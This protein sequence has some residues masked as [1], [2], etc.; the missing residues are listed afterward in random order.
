MF[1]FLTTGSSRIGFLSPKGFLVGFVSLFVRTTIDHRAV[2]NSLP[3]CVPK[4]EVQLL[5]LA[6]A[7]G[8]CSGALIFCYSSTAAKTGAAPLSFYHKSKELPII[9]TLRPVL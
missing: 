3:L 6:L 4:Q 9:E 8:S 7:H 2:G 5:V 1:S